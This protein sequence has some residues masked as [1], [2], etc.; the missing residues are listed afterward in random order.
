MV[1]LYTHTHFI[2]L[3]L[4]LEKDNYRNKKKKMN[5]EP[6]SWLLDDGIGRSLLVRLWSPVL[7]FYSSSPCLQ[8]LLQ[9]QVL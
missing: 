5:L 6:L 9:F 3:I 1:L 8:R 2:F 7:D 4:L